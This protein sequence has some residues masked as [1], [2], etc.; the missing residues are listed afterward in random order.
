[1]KKVFLAL[2]VSFALLTGFVS[3]GFEDLGFDYYTTPIATA[4][5]LVPYG[6]SFVLYTNGDSST[7]YYVDF[8][9]IVTTDVQYDWQALYLVGLEGVTVADLEAYY[10]GKG[11]PWESYLK[12]AA[13]GIKAFAYID[14]ED[15][16]EGPFTPRI[17]AG[18]HHFFGIADI[19]MRIPGDYPCG[20]YTV[21]TDDEETTFTIIIS[22]PECDAD[23]DGVSNFEDYCLETKADSPDVSLGVNRWIWDGDSWETTKPKGKGKGPTFAPTMEYT[24]GCSCEQI[25]EILKDKTYLDFEGHD[26]FGCSQSIL[27]EWNEGWYPLD[28]I[29]VSPYNALPEYPEP[30]TTNVMLKELE[31][32]KLIASGVWERLGGNM[33]DAQ[34]SAKTP[35]FIWGEQGDYLNGDLTINGNHLDWGPLQETTHIYEMAYLP[36]VDEYTAFLIW[37]NDPAKYVDN[38]DQPLTVDVI[39]KL[40]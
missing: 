33:F 35:N 14:T 37:M 27:Q 16:S 38:Y 20:K 40:R 26:K 4:G 39:L 5:E 3:A 32:Y 23:G 30:T 21:Q 25:L 7:D 24:L 13:N 2:L 18:L 34:Y 15:A 9:D 29:L 10:T 6:D 19:E 31:E 8:K 1:M 12:A 11:E 36:L 22:S 17:Y 28:S